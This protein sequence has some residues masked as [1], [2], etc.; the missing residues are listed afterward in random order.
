MKTPAPSEMW[1]AG[2][3]TKPVRDV[4]SDPYAHPSAGPSEVAA[5]VKD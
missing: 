2:F 4:S 1:I 5:I 3:V